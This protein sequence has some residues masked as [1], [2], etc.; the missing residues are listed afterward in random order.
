MT[1]REDIP[2]IRRTR[3]IATLGPASMEPAR[4]E[5]MIRAGVN[6]F[7]LNFSHGEAAT[8]R[9]T[10]QMLHNAT[11]AAGA[12]VGVLQDLQGPKLRVGRFIDGA[13]DL[14]EG[15]QFELRS[16]GDELGDGHGVKISYPSLGKDIQ[17][18]Q[19]ILLDDGRIELDVQDIDEQRIMTRVVTGGRLSDLKGINV[20][21][22][23]LAIPALTDKDIEDLKAGVDLG[24]DWIALSFVRSR[25]DLKLARHY[26]D[27]FGS[28]AHLMAKIEKPGA[29][30]DFDA[31]LEAADGIMIARGDLGVELSPQAIPALQKSLI[32]KCRAAGKPVV[33][34][35]EMLNS[36]VTSPR[37]SRAE[38]SDV[39]NAIYD[40]TDAVMLSAE[41]AVGDYPVDAV[42]MM[43]AI[44]LEVEADPAYREGMRRTAPQSNHNHPGR[45]GKR[46]LRNGA[47][48]R[49]RGHCEL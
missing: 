2:S 20:P 12:D 48:R 47:R 41:T 16:H 28:K 21:G 23:D 1:A 25:D 26:M 31:I 40:G 36:M 42:A 30:R 19:R 18:G 38:A 43:H 35:T 33:T 3:I 17:A 39:A 15:D 6:V 44:A 46:G 13:I 29:V 11:R 9:E 10:M 37:P 14:S 27:R 34:A 32:R 49:R 4:L 22:A 7:R 8:H 45:R 5:A 24:V